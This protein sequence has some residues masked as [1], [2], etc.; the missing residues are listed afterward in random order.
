MK[1]GVFSPNDTRLEQ[2]RFFRRLMH[3]LIVIGIVAYLLAMYLDQLVVGT[4]LYWGCFLGFIAVWQGTSLDL[5]DERDQRLERAAG[6]T[7]LGLFAFVVVFGIPGLVLLAEIG[8]YE[9]PAVLWGVMYGYASIF[10]VFGVVYT[11]T[12]IRA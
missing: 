6:N 4:L 10:I 8:L 12:R 2:V 7:T 3:G 1:F 5:Y 11:V 9:A